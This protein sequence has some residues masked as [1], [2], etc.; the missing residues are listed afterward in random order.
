MLFGLPFST[1]LERRRAK[2]AVSNLKA[3]VSMFRVTLEVR[4]ILVR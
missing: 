2:A 3:K 4:K 1:L